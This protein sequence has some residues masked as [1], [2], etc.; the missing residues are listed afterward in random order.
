MQPSSGGCLK[1]NLVQQ[2]AT[3]EE[4]CDN[5]TRSNFFSNTLCHEAQIRILHFKIGHDVPR[6]RILGVLHGHAPD[7]IEIH[8]FS[9]VKPRRGSGLGVYGMQGMETK[10][11]H[12]DVHAV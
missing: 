2:D 7:K 1:V 10:I 12:S 6:G 4:N 8:Y 9:F 5:Y 3:I 11:I